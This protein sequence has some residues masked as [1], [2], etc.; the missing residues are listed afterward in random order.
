MANSI[1]RSGGILGSSLGKTSA[2]SQT[3]RILSKGNS[4]MVK[5]QEC[6]LLWLGR[7]RVTVHRSGNGSQ[8]LG[9]RHL[10]KPGVGSTNQFPK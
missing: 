2:Y 9:S 10:I 5:A 7:Y 6:A 4:I 1:S 8:R 3:T